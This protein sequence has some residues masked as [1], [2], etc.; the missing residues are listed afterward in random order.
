[1]KTSS[2]RGE[3]TLVVIAAVAL[4]GLGG[5]M[6]S[7]NPSTQHQRWQFWRKTPATLAANA[8]AK[9]ADAKAAEAKLQA[10]IDE[11]TRELIGKAQE[12]A[13]AA[14]VAAGATVN[15]IPAG[16]P[17]AREAVT[18]KT[19]T[20]QTV[21]QLG[22]ATGETIDPKR[23]RELETMV[24]DLNAD[25]VA[26]RQ[27]L[28]AM[29]SSY[30]TELAARKALEA[31]LAQ[32]E[33]KTQAAEEIARKANAQAQEWGAERDAVASE[34]ERLKFGAGALVVV[35]LGLSIWLFGLRRTAGFATKAATDLVAL[36]EHVK[37]EFAR[38][39]PEKIADLKASVK[40]WVGDDHQL[41]AYVEKIKT[42]LRR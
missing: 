10:G 20:S 41:A 1:M 37:E 25:R 28:A 23:V 42:Q 40:T 6:F 35:I 30:D 18:T 3:A 5:F 34:Y 33:A 24:A 26:G 17:G 9:A 4:I 27:A 11:K 14:D 13:T 8:D 36:H 39:A 19:L 21:T 12:S 31:R 38:V 2:R 29:Q 15:A 22:A 32:A 16:A 7:K